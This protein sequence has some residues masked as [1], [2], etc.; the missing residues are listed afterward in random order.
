MKRNNYIRDMNKRFLTF[1]AM[2]SLA[3]GLVAQ[4]AAKSES[5]PLRVY[6]TPT[7]LAP[8]VT[9]HER[10]RDV[11]LEPGSLRDVVQELDEVYSEVQR[12][13]GPQEYTMPNLVWT[14]DVMDLPVTASLRLMD[15]GAVD[16]L[17]LIAAAAGCKLEVVE[18]IQPSGKES[19]IIGYKFV[20][21]ATLA[22]APGIMGGSSS[23]FA[24]G[25]AGFT[26]AVP[27]GVMTSRV[28][29]PGSAMGPAT[30]AFQ[31]Q[32]AAPGM[33]GATA[34]TTVTSSSSPQAALRDLQGQLT[35][36]QETLGEQHPQV[37]AIKRQIEATE[38]LDA[39]FPVTRVYALGDILTGDS[40]T[41]S[42]QMSTL[43]NTINDVLKQ[44]GI[45]G[46]QLKFHDG[47]KVLVIKASESAHGLISQVIEA[48]RTN[49]K[50]VDSDS[51]PPVKK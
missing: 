33:S 36:F 32:G 39:E 51:K 38:R 40:Q 26:A 27:P 13:N 18:S 1:C 16:A 21:V 35:R 29:A 48:L 17:T 12:N 30:V 8:E 3:T 34:I 7:R 42:I 9:N 19:K 50:S 20:R 24:H 28:I 14:Q 47:A 23:S 45:A 2:L 6:P 37:L 22:N 4:P 10:Y 49:A 43:S 46:V 25:N 31:A 5:K 15:V 11:T 44:E 41:R